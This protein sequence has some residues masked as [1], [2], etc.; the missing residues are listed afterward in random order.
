[1]V[2][3]LFHVCAVVIT[4]YGYRTC[5]GCTTTSAQSHFSDMD[6]WNIIFLIGLSLNCVMSERTVDFTTMVREPRHKIQKMNSRIKIS[7]TQPTNI[8][9]RRVKPKTLESGRALP[10]PPI[11]LD[12]PPKSGKKGQG[13]SM[14]RSVCE[15]S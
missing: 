5:D 12:D 15:C 9:E 6:N 11:S 8:G 4:V 7:E 2:S 1:M 13:E 14:C 3:A 10:S